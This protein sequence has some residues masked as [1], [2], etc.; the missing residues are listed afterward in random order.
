MN[1]DTK[2]YQITTLRA[3]LAAFI[4]AKR[5]REREMDATLETYRVEVGSQHGVKPGNIVGAIA[6]ETGLSGREIGPIRITDTY[7]VVGVPESSVE[8]VIGAMSSSTLRGKRAR[9]RR[10]V[11]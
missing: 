5:K 1:K 8:H 11:D 6:N 7:S 9:I 3:L 10:F 2:Y 4:T